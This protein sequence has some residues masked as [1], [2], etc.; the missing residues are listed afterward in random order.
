MF[1]WQ[2]YVYFWFWHSFEVEKVCDTWLYYSMKKILVVEDD[3]YLVYAYK[4]K[5][6]KSG[7]KV[8]MAVDGSQAL[9][10]MKKFMPD[11]VILDLIM[12]NVDGF[13]FLDTVKRDENFK[14]I[15]V[16]VASNLGQ[17]ED[18]D[19]AKSLGAVDYFVKSDVSLEKIIEIVTAVL[20][21]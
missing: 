13:S 18:V 20:S 17:K 2:Y 6:L 14:E 12:P 5:L 19:R 1:Q 4:Q 21:K 10:A 15:P 16:I 11:V 9:D 3:P 8:E 7:F